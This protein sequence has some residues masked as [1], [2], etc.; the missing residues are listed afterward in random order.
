MAKKIVI[1]TLCSVFILS[2]FILIFKNQKIE[3]SKKEKINVM[4]SILP[5]IDFVKNIGKDKIDVCAMIPPGFSPA[6][7]EPS[8]NQLKKLSLANLYIRVGHIPFEKIQMEK[9]KRLNLKMK[10]IDSSNGIEIYENDP[11][12]WMSP[13]MV[14]IQVKNICNALIKADFANRIFY[15]NN[16]KEYLARLDNLDIE[17]KNAFSKMQGRKILVFHPAFGYLARE[18][19]FEQIAVEIGGKEPGAKNLAHIINEA[20]K[21]NIKIIFVQ[22]QFS[23][24]SAESIAKQ[25]NGK[26]VPLNPLAENYI[27][28]LRNIAE[29]IQK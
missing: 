29:E 6:T 26:V 16:E 4:V 24:K 9:I 2:I 12:I 15:K 14:K 10:V 25:I 23:A 19:G 3:T 27:E 8:P 28:N 11:H 22:K 17:L 18:Y 13:K 1:L 20:K 7:Y 5:Q 21:E